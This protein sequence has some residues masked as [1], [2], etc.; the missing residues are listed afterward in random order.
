[1]WLMT[2][3]RM[4]DALWEALDRLPAGEAGIV[5]R[6][7]QLPAEA[8]R[9]LA[10]RVASLA[11]ARNLTLAISRDVALADAVGADLVH[12]PAGESASLPFSRAVHDAAEAEA[13][14]L[15][16]AALVFVSP[17]FPTRSHPDQPALGIASA[18]ALARAAVV[19]SIALGGVD[20]RNFQLLREAG[21][22]GWAGIDAWLAPDQNLNAVPT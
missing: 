9:D 19:P 7:H 15:E 16:G 4:G 3:E 13:A 8:R 20:A 12:N 1:M 5:L 2:D 22:Y 11:R 18:S 17:V 10:S 14:R 21:F 6:H